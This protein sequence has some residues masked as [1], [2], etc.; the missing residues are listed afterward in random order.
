MGPKK[1]FPKFQRKIFRKSCI[2]IRWETQEKCSAQKENVIICFTVVVK[3][4]SPPPRTQKKFLRRVWSFEFEGVICGRNLNYFT[5]P[6]IE[7]MQR[8]SRNL[9]NFSDGFQGFEFE[10]V[11]GE[12]NLTTT[13]MFFHLLTTPP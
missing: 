4:I 7:K 10:E 11:R 6:E 3:F 2:K 8:K 5:C 13:V 12:I 9:K 1:T